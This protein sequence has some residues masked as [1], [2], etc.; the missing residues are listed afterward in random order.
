MKFMDII[1]ASAAALTMIACTSTSAISGKTLNV[2]ELNGTEYVSQTE[3]TANMQFSENNL[4]ATVGGNAINAQ[5]FE[6]KDGKLTIS[7]GLSTKM[8]VP[9]EFREDEFVAAINSIAA[10]KVDGEEVS[11]LDADGK[12]IIKTVVAE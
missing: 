8:M 6:G 4:S 2:T 5:Y 1:A 3:T 9:E 11:F 10:Y 12:I 7:N